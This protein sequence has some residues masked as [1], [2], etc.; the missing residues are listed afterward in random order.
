[1][2]FL[3]AAAHASS[4]LLWSAP[5]VIDSAPTAPGNSDSRLDGVSCPS[6]A[7]CV[8]VD[9][10]GSIV[11]SASGSWHVTRVGVSSL[12]AVSCPSIVL[13]VA[14]SG[15]GAIVSSTNPSGGAGAWT[16]VTLAQAYDL[17]AVSC[18]TVALCI[19]IDRDTGRVLASTNPTGG[20]G[21]WSV[22]F[23]DPGNVFTGPGPLVSAVSC[24]SSSLCVAAGGVVLTSVT[25][26]IPGSWKVTRFSIPGDQ[27]PYALMGV[28]CPSASLCVA[29]DL[30]GTILSSTNPTGG[31]GAWHAATVVRSRSYPTPFSP[32]LGA[33]SCP[34]VS[35]CT[36]AVHDASAGLIG[37]LGDCGS[38]RCL[39]R[40]D[41]GGVFVSTTPTGAASAWSPIKL[42]TPNS[43]SGLSCPSVSLCAAVD[44]AGNL[45]VGAPT[46]VDLGA[47]RGDVTTSV[48]RI[49]RHAGKY[50][51]TTG[52]TVS[53]PAQAACTVTGTAVPY[54]SVRVLGRARTS[55]P[56]GG[57]RSIAIDL[58]PRTARR[59]RLQARQDKFIAIDSDLLA[60][61]ASGPALAIKRLE[62]ITGR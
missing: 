53:C 36:V 59:L 40:L 15:S 54:G 32:T 43:I 19:A 2:T 23:A 13:C 17:S 11:E 62:V 51:L 55:I 50:R 25:P 38:A 60:R 42:D 22:V 24:A 48:M 7:L 26:S 31:A 58:T 46:A 4:P 34:S 61:T 14:V 27:S 6:V 47:P 5:V 35:L 1:L 45:T 44:E 12:H 21:A 30:L 18:P 8:A 39:P 57:R 16:T 20:A 9:D 28:S 56:A 3:P 37:G 52:L 29:T 49:S 10:A 41:D 33:V